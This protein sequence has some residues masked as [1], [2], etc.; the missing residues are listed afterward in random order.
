MVTDFLFQPWL[1]TE[2]E[3]RIYYNIVVHLLICFNVIIY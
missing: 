3:G 2:Q 1:S